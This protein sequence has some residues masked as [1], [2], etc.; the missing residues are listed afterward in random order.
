[1]L[2]GCYKL[3]D[4]KMLRNTFC[5]VFLKLFFKFFLFYLFYKLFINN[6]RSCF[7]GLVHLFSMV[8]RDFPSFKRRLKIINFSLLFNNALQIFA[9]S[10]LVV[11]KHLWKTFVH[12]VCR[13]YFNSKFESLLFSKF[14]FL[15][16]LIVALTLIFQLA[17][18]LYKILMGWDFIFSELSSS[19][20]NK[21]S[22]LLSRSFTFNLR[23]HLKSLVSKSGE[24]QRS[25]RSIVSKEF[26]SNTLRG[27]EEF[28]SFAVL[29]LL[30]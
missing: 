8:Y 22:W 23:N 16:Y 19:F 6:R 18:L 20:W 3:L 13:L 17:N 10:S 14:V 15:N 1:M 29:V 30:N 12:L 28:M 27:G 21:V 24:I 26:P 7:H 4:T 11:F 25:K 9:H 5:Y 2:I